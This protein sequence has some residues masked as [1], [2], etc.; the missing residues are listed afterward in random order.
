VGVR[1]EHVFISASSGYLRYT[2][3]CVASIRRWYPEIPISLL[4]DEANGPYSTRELEEAWNVSIFESDRPLPGRGWAR[5]EPMFLPDRQ[6]S[7][8]IDSDIVFLGKVLEPLEA[9]DADFIVESRG[10]RPGWMARDY[11]D[12]V[13]LKE[14]DPEF[15]FPGY[16]FNGGQLVATSGIL[17]RADFDHLVSFGAK[18]EKVYPDL[19]GGVNQGI[20]NYVL[21]QRAQRGELTLE[22]VPFMEWGFNRLPR[23]GPNAVS[24][25]RL[26][27]SSPYRYLVHWAGKKYKLFFLMRNGRLLRHFEA[28]YYSRIPGGRHKRRWRSTALLWRILTRQEQSRVKLITEA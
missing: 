21:L 10:G 5:L 18:P 19:F 16:T 28:H 14:V 24:T 15:A 7:L 2:Q 3:C 25:R 22:R 20:I 17:K 27:G 8:I 23:L 12:P 13:A 1:I 11:F 9:V 26:T 6:R 4:K